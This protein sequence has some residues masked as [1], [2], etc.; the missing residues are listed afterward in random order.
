MGQIVQILSEKELEIDRIN[1]H[2]PWDIT[3]W[4]CA[5]APYDFRPRFDVLMRHYRYYFESPFSHLDLSSMRRALQLLIGSHDFSLLS[6]PDGNRP[7]VATILNGCLTEHKGTLT[8]DLFGTNFL[9]KLVRKT[10]SL[11]LQIG[12][13]ASKLDIITDII[14]GRDTIPGGIRPA[15]PECLVLIETVVPIRMKSTKHAKKRIQK[16]VSSHLRS[17]ERSKTTIA[18]VNEDY[19]S[20]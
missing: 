18:A 20:S 11:L 17:L 1:R 12:T 16:H 10:V 3:L 8:I 15:P 9:W 2:L 19:F 7:T 5:E 6:K 13:G 14:S 4:A